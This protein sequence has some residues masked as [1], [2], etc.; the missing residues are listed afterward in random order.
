MTFLVCVIERGVISGKLDQYCLL[1]VILFL[2]S[3]L[4]AC[5][6]REKHFV[7]LF[8][9]NSLL[10]ILADSNATLLQLSLIS[11]FTVGYFSF[12]PGEASPAD[13]SAGACADAF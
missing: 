1:Q 13:S 3:S 9:L 12:S 7:E 5:N 10:D 8:N 2:N 11:H 4:N 6:K